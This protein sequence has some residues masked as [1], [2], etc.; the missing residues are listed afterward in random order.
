[1]KTRIVLTC[2]LNDND[3]LLKKRELFEE[4]GFNFDFNLI[5]THY[6]D[7]AKIKNYQLDNYI[8]EKLCNI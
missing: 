2:I 8:K 4:I 7:E 5:I 3:D 6:T 1:M